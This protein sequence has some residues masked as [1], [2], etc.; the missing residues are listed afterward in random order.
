MNLITADEV[1][2]LTT[3]EQNLSNDIL[4]PQ[5]EVAQLNHIKPVLGDT[6][7]EALKTNPSQYSELYDKIKRPLA[8]WVFYESAVFLWLRMTNKGLMKRTSEYAENVSS[9]DFK[10]FRNEIREYAKEHT[11][12]LIQYLEKSNLV[13]YKKQVSGSPTQKNNANVSGIFF[14]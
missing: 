12:I 13:G 6:L 7:Y 10:F 3:I 5:I 14:H 2:Q 9:E 11:N 1:K 4:F 8:F